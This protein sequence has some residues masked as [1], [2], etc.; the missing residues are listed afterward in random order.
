MVVLTTFSFIW[1]HPVIGFSTRCRIIRV[2]LYLEQI[3][4]YLLYCNS[5]WPQSGRNRYIIRGRLASVE[6]NIKI[7][8][9]GRHHLY[10]KVVN[11]ILHTV[12]LDS[13]ALT[14]IYYTAKYYEVRKI[15]FLAYL[16]NFLS[17][18]KE[19]CSHVYK[20]FYCY[21]ICVF[22]KHSLN[23]WLIRHYLS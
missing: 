8:I 17:S 11:P 19:N 4:K 2:S 15:W 21:N 6:E 18:I 7:I 5:R 12:W 23:E 16:T 1:P 13:H 10:D 20:V 22:C 3:S 14:L 9:G